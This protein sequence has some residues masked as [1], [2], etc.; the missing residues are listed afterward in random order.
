VAA[1]SRKARSGELGGDPTRLA[2][3]GDSAGGNLSAA[4]A[5]QARLDGPPLAAVA[6]VYP[7]CD[8]ACDAASYTANGDGYLL[9]ARD[10]HWFWRCYLGSAG[11]PTDPLASP[12]QAPDLT[13]LPPT[14]IITA[15]FDPLRDEAEA[16]AQRLAAA[17]VPVDV[18]RFD[19]MLHGFLGMDALVPEA[20]AAMALLG[21]FLRTRLGTAALAD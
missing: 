18:H 11:D 9:T 13:G 10:M 15:E 1:W 14:L 2:V 20:D 8:A 21:D 17:D 7:V 16:Y 4:V 6:L 12:L 3:A 19:R 5:L